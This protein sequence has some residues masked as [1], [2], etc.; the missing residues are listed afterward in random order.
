MK[1]NKGF[2]IF[3]I[4]I[5]CCI[6]LFLIVKK[7]YQQ[8]NVDVLTVELPRLQEYEII[9]YNKTKI[10][11]GGDVNYYFLLELEDDEFHE[12]TSNISNDGYWLGN[13]MNDNKFKSIL[14]D[15]KKEKIYQKIISEEYIDF[16]YGIKNGRI[17]IVIFIFEN[18]NI[19]LFISNEKG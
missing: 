14:S 13:N 9:A 15:F 3:A 4:L 6:M 18:N 8:V 17:N 1:K 7:T 16:Y 5:S 19:A 2:V 12:F 10:S 11:V